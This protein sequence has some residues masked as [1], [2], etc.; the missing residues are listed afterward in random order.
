MGNQGDRVLTSTGS[1]PG[2]CYADWVFSVLFSR[3]LRRL[4]EQLMASGLMDM[5]PV[6]RQPGL[7]GTH[8]TD[9]S[10]PLMGPVWMDDL[11][12]CL[13]A[14]D[15]DS[16]V[17][18]AGRILSELLTVCRAH[19]MQ[20]N[21]SAGKTEV[22]L[23][24]MQTQELSQP[25]GCM[26]CKVV[27]RSRAGE[28]VHM[29]KKHGHCAKE[30]L[31]IDGTQCSHCLKEYH[32]YSKL[33]RHL[34]HSHQCRQAIRPVRHATDLLPGIGSHVDRAQVRDL[35]DLVPIQQAEGPGRPQRPREEVP[36]V[37]WT[38]EEALLDLLHPEHGQQVVEDS[39]RNRL[40][41][42]ISGLPVSWTSCRATLRYMLNTVTVHDFEDDLDTFLVTQNVL[43]A[44]AEPDAWEFLQ[45]A[46]PCRQVPGSRTLEDLTAALCDGPPAGSL[47]EAPRPPL[48]RHRVVL[49]LFS[50]RRRFGDLQWF[51]ERLQPQEG[52]TLHTISIDLVFHEQWGD[53]SREHTQQWL[54]A[55]QML[56]Q[57]PGFRLTHVWQGFFGS[58]S[59]KPTHI[60]SL[61]VSRLED[62]LAEHQVTDQL[63]T[64]T[65][66]GLAGDGCWHTTALKEYP[67]ALNHGFAQAMID[68]L[69]AT[70]IGSQLQSE[71]FWEMVQPMQASFGD[72][73]GLDCHL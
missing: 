15:A 18:K 30:R 47:V 65:S 21:L 64:N 6:A 44:L 56:L 8:A 54:A 34:R 55:V 22:L 40:R 68:F 35:D 60:L 23:Q 27:L 59:P 50:G 32:T 63:P 66:I 62:V 9:R 3:V 16:L 36:D 1:R 39:L 49:H 71:A 26:C 61:N 11:A 7:D 4:E 42:C 2:D 12:I 72:S 14:P 10:V 57:L 20:P 69:R 41:D 46:L 38:L 58:R 13:S 28:S 73:I 67:P 70:P 19:G 52:T 5:I 37:D 24:E 31:F 33:Q 29:H 48:G 25:Y 51:L 45:Q 17:L 43:A 53:L